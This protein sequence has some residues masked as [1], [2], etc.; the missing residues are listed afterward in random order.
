MVGA[1]TLNS[2]ELKGAALA[3]RLADE[4]LKSAVASSLEIE[5]LKVRLTALPWWRWRAKRQLLAEIRFHIDAGRRYV[6]ISAML[7]GDA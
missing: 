4:A 5:R 2:H 1:T 6:W 3:S 7:D